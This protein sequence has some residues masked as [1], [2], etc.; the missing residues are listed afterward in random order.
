MVQLD[1]N[2]AQSISQGVNID[3]PTTDYSAVHPRAKRVDRTLNLDVK[4]SEVV[5]LQS[6]PFQATCDCFLSPLKPSLA[7]M[8]HDS[9]SPT[10]TRLHANFPRETLSKTWRTSKTTPFPPFPSSFSMTKNLLQCQP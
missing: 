8:A 2:L 10:G 9:S 4:V 1:Q 5:G 3:R 6:T 7:G